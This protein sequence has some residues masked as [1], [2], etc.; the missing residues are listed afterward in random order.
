MLLVVPHIPQRH[1]T[2]RPRL[3][4]DAAGGSKTVDSF[5][6]RNNKRRIKQKCNV[7]YSKDLRTTNLITQ[8]GDFEGRN[9]HLSAN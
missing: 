9:F 6:V 2:A 1:A 3:D 4:A 7:T 8:D 5:P